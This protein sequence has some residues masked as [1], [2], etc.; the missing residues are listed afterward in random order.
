MPFH[1]M[2]CHVCIGCMPSRREIPTTL[3]NQTPATQANL[4]IIII[5]IIIACSNIIIIFMHQHS[6][7]HLLATFNSN[8]LLLLYPYPKC[9]YFIEKNWLSTT[10]SYSLVMCNFNSI[11]SG[12][13]PVSPQ[14][15]VK[16]NVGQ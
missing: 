9:V 16:Q 12:I 1:S 8:R 2:A 6:K 5:I 3:N 13:T 11:S 15:N 4:K 14:V 7:A 10:A